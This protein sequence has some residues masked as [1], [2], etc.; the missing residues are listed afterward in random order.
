MCGARFCSSHS[1]SRRSAVITMPTSMPCLATAWP[2]KADAV[3]YITERG[4]SARVSTVCHAV[5]SEEHTSK[6]QSREN[7]VCRLLLEKQKKSKSKKI[8]GMRIA[9]KQVDYRYVVVI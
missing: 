2:R 8:A 1:C 6:L 9:L 7:L 4:P 3:G 5:R